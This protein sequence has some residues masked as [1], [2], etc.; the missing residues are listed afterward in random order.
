M[1]A[2]PHCQKPEIGSMMKLSTLVLVRPLQCP[3]CGGLS[4][5]PLRYGVFALFTWVIL[6]WLF[7]MTALYFR[8]VFYL[9]GS[10]PAAILAVDKWMLRAPLVKLTD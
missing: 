4:Y 8:S 6:S 1:H 5:I 10:I 7:I 2:C 3:G 9:L